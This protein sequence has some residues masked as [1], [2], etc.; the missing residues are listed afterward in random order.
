MADT[1]SILGL[2]VTGVTTKQ[3]ANMWQNFSHCGIDLVKISV[4]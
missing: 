4:Y 2:K 1:T 3:E